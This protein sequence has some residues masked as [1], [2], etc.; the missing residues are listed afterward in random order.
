LKKLIPTILLCFLLTGV[1]GQRQKEV[2][3]Y[4]WAQYNKT[5]YDGT[6]GNNPSGVGL[7][8]Q[9][10]FNNK[11]KFKPTI[12]LSGDIYLEDDKVLRTDINGTP[13]NEVPGMI[14][15]FVDSS[16]H[17]TQNIYLSFVAGLSFI[18]G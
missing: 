9:T 3:T 2:T 5:I 14:N 10:F 17:P 8:L 7:G 4:L 16:F 12:E 13:V 18:G 1:F 6:L 15:L 11:T